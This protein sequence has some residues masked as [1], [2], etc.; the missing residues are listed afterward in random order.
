MEAGSMLRHTLEF[1]RIWQN[2]LEYAPGSVSATAEMFQAILL[3]NSAS[4]QPHIAE[5]A[6]ASLV[7]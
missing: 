5:F 6:I 3:H 1:P 2:V 4:A 7:V